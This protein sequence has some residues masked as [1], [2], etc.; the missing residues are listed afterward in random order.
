MT[1]EATTRAPARTPADE[2]L[3]YSARSSCVRPGPVVSASSASDSVRG[4][5]ALDAAP[6]GWVA[7][8]GM[9]T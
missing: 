6:M 5:A 7:P 2:R 1:M 8:T 3:P 4:R 9:R